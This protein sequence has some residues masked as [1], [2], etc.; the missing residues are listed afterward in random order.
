[1]PFLRPLKLSLS[2]F[3]Y[4]TDQATPGLC[5]LTRRWLQ[6][7]NDLTGC[8]VSLSITFLGPNWGKRLTSIQL[9]IRV[10]CV[11]TER[12]VIF[13]SWCHLQR[14]STYRKSGEISTFGDRPLFTFWFFTPNE[15][16]RTI[17]P[18]VHDH[19]IGS[20]LANVCYI[21]YSHLIASYY[22][23]FYT[24]P[25]IPT[26]YIYAY[27]YIYDNKAFAT[28]G[29]LARSYVYVLSEHLTI[30]ILSP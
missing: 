16:A 30:A 21:A 22:I 1:M 6:S 11:A 10:N 12:D 23:T 4:L 29:S 27:I 2:S 7:A 5:V 26:C 18:W 19:Q 28:S 13:R 24:R 17:S 14:A 20:N 25:Y 15:F 9:H 3:P 8:W